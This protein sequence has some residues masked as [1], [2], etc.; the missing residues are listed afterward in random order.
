M[1]IG[2]RLVTLITVQAVVLLII[3]LTAIAGLNY[4]TNT[5][6]RLNQNVI[7]QVKLNLLQQ[8]ISGDMMGVVNRVSR[9]SQ[10]WGEAGIDLMA[11]RA[12]FENNWR[13]Y[14]SDRTAEEK[15]EIKSSMGGYITNVR[16]AF[17]QLE[18]LFALQDRQLLHEFMRDSLDPLVNPMLSD[19]RGRIGEQQIA[20]EKSFSESAEANREFF[21]ESVIVMIAGL[22]VAILLGFLIYRSIKQPVNV[23]SKTV[24]KVSDGDFYARTN[25]A[26]NDELGELGKAFDNLL[27][28]KV[29]T[30][31]K[32][33]QEN[34]ML[35]ESVI[36]LL[37]A[38]SKLSKRDLTVRIP[39]TEDIT[40]PVAD[41]L[42]V[43]TSET[44]KVLQGVR[45]I[46]EEVARASAKV[47]AQSDQVILVASQER[48]EVIE[49]AERLAEAARAM[50]D[51]AELADSSNKA[52]EEA[53]ETTSI[54]R[55][56][57]TSTV[58]GI[59][60][61][62]E[63]IHETEKRIKRLGERSQEISRAVNLIN[64]ISERTHILALNASMHAASAGEAG[65]GFAV[66]ADEVQ[67]LAENARDAT[68]QISTLVNNIQVETSDTVATMNNVITQVVEG[69]ELAEKAG[70]Q[71]QKTQESTS[72]L[73]ASVKQIASSS[74]EQARVANQLQLRADQI[75]ESTIQTSEQLQQQTLQTNRLVQYAKSLLNAVQVFKLP[76]TS[77]QKQAEVVDASAATDAEVAHKKAS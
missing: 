77:K 6:A 76:G 65:K 59:N 26:G 30:L 42:N 2:S 18:T 10:G 73:V 31:V 3:G 52:A 50:N 48:E 38:V 24:A 32:T 74:V 5:T 60:N 8:S 63:I 16:E 56:T 57:V 45:S 62:R 55:E 75:K 43:L 68:A 9:G 33:E 72:H 61:I 58:V 46:S 34:T 36:A 21:N 11:A 66:V 29:A 67:R 41:A 70:Q 39:V 47:K 19:L 53:I 44:S 49:T 14:L 40:G 7:E 51:I 54:A 17:D 23:I 69:S 27:E 35:N 20:S 64:S 25:L 4:A 1:K 22:S 71:M 15:A 13:E 12:V 37:Q 28:D